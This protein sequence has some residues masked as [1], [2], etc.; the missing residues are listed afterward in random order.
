M[1]RDCHRHS[2][3]VNKYILLLSVD[4]VNI[5]N[6]TKCHETRL[7][8][9]FS[10]VTSVMLYCFLWNS[11]KNQTWSPMS[12]LVQT[13]HEWL[14]WST[15]H[16]DVVFHQ[17]Q[18][19]GSS[20]QRSYR[21]TLSSWRLAL[22]SKWL[23]NRSL[24][25]ASCGWSEMCSELAQIMT[26]RTTTTMTTTSTTR[27][28]MLKLALLLPCSPEVLKFFHCLHKTK[29]LLWQ[30]SYNS[31]TNCDKAAKK[32]LYTSVANSRKPI[33]WSSSSIL[34]K[35]LFLSL[36]TVCKLDERVADRTLEQ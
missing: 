16:S 23:C 21:C 12:H 36:L 29:P 33:T 18:W 34:S 14:A 20:R 35:I 22:A 19:H 3:V 15:S 11:A 1:T 2:G 13:R 24:W 27:T 31:R 26:M 25:V 5:K 9:S 8:S 7:A 28:H 32:R 17:W 4:N 6:A 30:M 10:P